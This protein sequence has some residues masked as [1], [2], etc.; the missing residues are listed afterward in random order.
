MKWET[1]AE[2]KIP[3]NYDD[4]LDIKATIVLEYKATVRFEYNI[5]RDNTTIALGYT[6]HSFVDAKTR[7]PVRP[8]RELFD[9]IKNNI[10]KHW[11]DKLH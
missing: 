1:E 3:A 9:V 4:L 11:L 10:E 2:Y 8:P 6:V 7:R 5:L